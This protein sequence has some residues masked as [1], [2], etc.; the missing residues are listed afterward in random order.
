MHKTHLVPLIGVAAA[1]FALVTLAYRR[2][3]TY[4]VDVGADDASYVEGFQEPQR[5]GDL[6]WRW[7]GGWARL[8]FHNAGQLVSR[9]RLRI[10]LGAFSAS[11]SPAPSISVAL[12]GRAVATFEAPGG[13]AVW[14][15]QLNQGDLGSGDW[16]LSMTSQAS[17]R[18]GQRQLGL[19]VDWAELASRPGSPLPPR[20]TT[21]LFLLSSLLLYGLL[22]RPLPE[23]QALFACLAAEVLAAGGLALARE[24]TVALLPALFAA[25]LATTAFSVSRASGFWGKLREFAP[26]RP[27]LA[28]IFGVVLCFGGQVLL[29]V[30][31]RIAGAAVLLLG[32]ASLAATSSDSK[33]T[34]GGLALW[35]EAGLVAAITALALLFRLHRLEEVPFAIFRDEARHGSVA[36]QMLATGS[37]P[38]LFLGPPINQPSPYFLALAAAFQLLGS[39]LHSLRLVSALAGAAAVP[40]TWW[41]IREAAGIRVALVAAFGLAVSSWHVSVSRFS[42]NYVEPTLF[43][44]P[45][46]LFLLRGTRSGRVRDFAL[47]GLFAGAAQYAS[48]T[49]KA[50]FIVLAALVL[51]EAIRRLR[52]RDR[53]AWRRL[54]VGY[55]VAAAAS[56]VVITPI[57]REVYRSPAGYTT[58]MRQVS[59]WEDAN[60]QGQYPLARLA[61][62]VRSY[63]GAFNVQGDM[64]G[65]HHMPGAPLLDPVSAACLAIGL[66]LV[67]GRLGESR[68]RF[69][70]YWAGGSMVPGL[71]T[72]D[73]PTATR[74]VEA[75]PALYAI[76]AFGAVTSWQRAA[77]LG[78]AP[79]L[80]RAVAG[81]L[82]AAA[83][84]YNGWLYFVAMYQSP[85]VWVKFAPVGTHLGQRLKALEAAG[86]LGADRVLFAPT[87]FVEHP[88]E[89][90]VMRFF[91]PRLEV[92]SF[93]EPGFAPRPG[94]LLVIPNYRA[95]WRRAAQTVTRNSAEAEVAAADLARWQAQLGSL[96]SS[97]AVAGPPFPST[98]DPTFWL[99]AWKPS[100]DSS[101]RVL[102]EAPATNGS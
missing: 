67:L 78:V 62:N 61:S 89:L 13:L 63:L 79:K 32:M 57:L 6:D 33:G 65:R 27:R 43:T 69:L 51:D 80:L 58:R 9:P 75:A 59:I 49:A 94:D 95:L 70:L 30:E 2:P 10:R 7:S 82:V 86:R 42:V 20:R 35:S 12:N 73:A 39:S 25:L 11:G 84:A 76:G 81:G 55:T 1:A 48:H 97:P 102:N 52:A 99:Y 46:Y 21:V 24:A 72:V 45:A 68:Y 28:L 22:A 17:E 37:L 47:C 87:A 101:E 15:F 54:L 74:I 3:F 66:A 40:V 85:S 98:S 88:D 29:S 34:A 93:D 19:R 50:V 4:R 71:V 64:N 92:R 8:H 5:R 18:R 56:L 23:R 26:L 44:L 90:L 96:L 53:L 14:Q 16:I 91:M 41:L 38:P 60:A 31:A 83:I 100:R 77:A 36:L